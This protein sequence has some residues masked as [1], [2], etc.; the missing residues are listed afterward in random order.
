VLHREEGFF[1]EPREPWEIKGDVPNV[2]FSC[3]QVVSNETL[4]VYYGG[5]DRVM[6]VATCPML[7]MMDSVTGK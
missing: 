3:G 6:A 7:E 4:Y 5:A 2:V 1:L